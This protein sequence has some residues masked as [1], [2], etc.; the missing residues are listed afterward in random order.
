MPG[1]AK[2]NRQQ[3]GDD[4]WGEHQSAYFK[5]FMRFIR[6]LYCELQLIAFFFN[7]A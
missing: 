3:G 2:E 1:K 4:K 5:L 6:A 7:G